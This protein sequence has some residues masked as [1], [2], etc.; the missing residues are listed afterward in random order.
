[1]TA[2]RGL[3]R[4]DGFERVAL[5]CGFDRDGR[6]GVIQSCERLEEKEPE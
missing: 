5:E 3:C 4:N 2:S 1:M 6:G